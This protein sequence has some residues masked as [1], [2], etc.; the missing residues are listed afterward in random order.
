[1]LLRKVDS[2]RRSAAVRAVASG[3][4]LANST[5][6]LVP[7]QVSGSHDAL[8]R[9]RGEGSNGNGHGEGSASIATTGL[10][11]LFLQTLLAERTCFAASESAEMAS[12][13]ELTTRLTRETLANMPNGNSETAG[14]SARR[15]QWQIS[16]AF[17]VVCFANHGRR[18]RDHFS[19]GSRRTEL[20]DALGRDLGAFGV[21]CF[22]LLQTA[23]V[24]QAAV[25]DGVAVR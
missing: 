2:L 9:K 1:M 17:A 22:E 19:F 3:G 20:V 12:L 25:G 23:E 10:V 4:E 18:R 21:E 6:P 8:G 7:E 14:V 24:G 5:Q 13:K 11:G 15:L 16:R